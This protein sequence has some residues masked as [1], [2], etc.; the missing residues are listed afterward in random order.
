MTKFKRVL[1]NEVALLAQMDHPGVIKLV[2]Y[3]LTGELVVKPGG[4]CIQIFFIV[5]EF[6][7][8]GD[9]FS[10]MEQGAFLRDSLDTSFYRW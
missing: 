6:I 10:I 8:N 2:E 4:Q 1:E 5:L 7:E 9:L 3:N